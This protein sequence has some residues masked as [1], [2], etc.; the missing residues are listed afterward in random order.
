MAVLSRSI[1]RLIHQLSAN[2]V[3]AVG[4]LLSAL[5]GAADF[6]AGADIS[7]VFFYLV[8]IAFVAWYA[9]AMRG[10]LV[11]L[12]CTFILYNVNALL[13]I[14]PQSLQLGLIDLATHLGFFLIVTTLLARQRDLLDRE[15]RASRT[16]FLT[17]ALNRRAFIELASSEIERARRHGHAFT[18]SYF[19]LDNFKTLNDD[20]GHAAGDAVLCRIVCIARQNLRAIDSIARLGGDEFALLLPETGSPAACSVVEKIF[21]IVQNEMMQNNWPVTLS[22]GVLTCE[23]PP[24]SVETMLRAADTLMY[25]VKS[26]GKNAILYATCNG[27]TATLEPHRAA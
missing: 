3:T 15:R 13:G 7:L 25:Q 27:E 20:L 14:N 9:D 24:Y 5:V 16:D 26:A 21:H 22:V 2:T 12:A 1:S 17:G 19:D 18:I 8:P 10:T 11:A 23:Q 4:L 6:A